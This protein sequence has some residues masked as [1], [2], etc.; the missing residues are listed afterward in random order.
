MRAPPSPS[1]TPASGDERVPRAS[2]SRASHHQ[3][4][5]LHSKIIVYPSSLL[6]FQRLHRRAQLGESRADP[7]NAVGKLEGR[8][9]PAGRRSVS[10]IVASRCRAR[11][12]GRRR[13]RRHRDVERQRR[14]EQSR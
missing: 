5:S 1:E 9:G 10:S 13:R 6:T 2:P 4:I 3:E 8:G 7:S 12:E 14:R 11:D